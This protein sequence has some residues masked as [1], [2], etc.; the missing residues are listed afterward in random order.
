MHQGGNAMLVL[1][2]TAGQVIVID[3]NIF[4]K[5][6]NDKRDGFKLA[7]DA[8]KDIRIVRGEIFEGMAEQEAKWAEEEEQKQQAKK[9]KPIH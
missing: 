9:R 6:V 4:I 5:V 2:R 7:I 3:D 1:G 8:P